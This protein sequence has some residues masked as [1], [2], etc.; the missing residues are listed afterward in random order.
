MRIVLSICFS[1]FLLV[2]S[3]NWHVDIHLC[4]DSV[5]SVT[6]GHGDADC[7]NNSACGKCCDNIHIDYLAEQDYTQLQSWELPQMEFVL[8]KADFKEL[9]AFTSPKNT[10]VFSADLSPPPKR[11]LFVQY[12]RLQFYG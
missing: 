9:R 6:L 7:G 2:F 8:L 10:I 5:K 3:T 11:K 1:I 12:R 4:H